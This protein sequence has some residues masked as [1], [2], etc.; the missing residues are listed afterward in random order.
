MSSG[1]NPTR[2]NIPGVGRVPI[3]GS[4]TRTARAGARGAARA[5]RGR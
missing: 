3:V 2:M 1:G 4:R 5:R